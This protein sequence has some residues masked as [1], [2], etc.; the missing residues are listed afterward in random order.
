MLS[1]DVKKPALCVNMNMSIS[2][3]IE[4]FLFHYKLATLQSELKR[5]LSFFNRVS[6]LSE[7]FEFNRENWAISE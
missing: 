2:F 5:L 3:D 6:H 7:Q 1:P 4:K